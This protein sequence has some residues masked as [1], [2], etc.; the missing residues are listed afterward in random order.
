MYPKEKFPKKAGINYLKQ[1]ILNIFTSIHKYYLY[2]VYILGNIIKL[3]VFENNNK[4]N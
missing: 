1:N 4:N 3:Y 2:C